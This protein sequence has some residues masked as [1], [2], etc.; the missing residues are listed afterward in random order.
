MVMSEFLLLFLWNF[1]HELVV[2]KSELVVTKS[3]APAS[4]L[5]S[6]LTI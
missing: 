1:P 2:K 5:A 6:S 3:M 4:P